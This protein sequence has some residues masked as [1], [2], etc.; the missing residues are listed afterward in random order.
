M[1]KSLFFAI[2][3]GMSKL[4][5][6]I[7]SLVLVLA[8]SPVTSLEAA[9][10]PPSDFVPGRLVVKVKGAEGNH[11]QAETLWARYDLTPLRRLSLTGASLVS[12]PLGQELEILAHLRQDTSVEYA[13]PDYHI[14]GPANTQRYTPLPLEANLQEPVQPVEPNDYFY[15]LQWAPLKIGAQQVWPYTTGGQDIVVAILSTGILPLHNEFRNRIVPGWDFVNN[16]DNPVEE[17]I[18]YPGTFQAGLALAR[19][20]NLDGIAGVSWNSGIMPVRILDENG[21]GSYSTL[22]EGL[23]YAAVNGAHVILVSAAGYHES[24]DLDVAIARVRA[25]TDAVI[26]APV[27]DCGRGP[28]PD[29]PA[30]PPDNAPAYPAANQNVIGVSATGVDDRWQDISGSGH[31]VK[32]SAPGGANIVSTWG[33]ERP[34][35]GYYL[36]PT[37]ST[38]NAAAHMAGV[39][40]L[41]YAVGGKPWYAGCNCLP[42]LSPLDIEGIL[43]RSSTDLGEPGWD[44]HYGWGRIDALKAIMQ[45]PHRLSFAEKDLAFTA[46]FPSSDEKICRLLHNPYTSA[47]TWGIQSDPTAK[48]LSVEQPDNAPPSPSPS[49]SR[50]CVSPKFVKAPGAY[51]ATLV[52]T[53]LMPLRDERQTEVHIPVKFVAI[54]RRASLYLPWIGK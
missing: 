48:W 22:V 5:C 1:T 23:Y 14:Y 3:K 54:T 24:Q 25:R 26:I 2:K 15:F 50:V 16:D 52:A 33:N 17:G 10:P 44:P 19:G 18:R 35:Y 41:I 30:C 45:T 51:T 11:L 47:S 34:Y 38:F 39:V 27:G 42:T 20:N 36:W 40:S 29:Y 4:R 37:S 12:V 53:N 6:L 7:A 13:E 43:R 9:A 28:S 31:Q 21:E 32:I 46:D 8:L 49:W